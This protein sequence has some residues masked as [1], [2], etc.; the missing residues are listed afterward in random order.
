MQILER[1][2]DISTWSSA[3]PLKLSL[4][5]TELALPSDETI[6]YVFHRTNFMD[7]ITQLPV[8]LEQHTDMR[9]VSAHIGSNDIFYWESETLK[10]TF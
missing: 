8:V 9:T 6:V 7:L 4:N 2:A 3:H 5:K 10:G 1:L